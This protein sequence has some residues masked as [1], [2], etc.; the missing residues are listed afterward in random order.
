MAKNILAVIGF[1]G[2]LILGVGVYLGYNTVGK[3]ESSHSKV[4]TEKD[5]T[6]KELRNQLAN[7]DQ[8]LNQLKQSKSPV[9]NPVA[10]SSSSE[11]D[12]MVEQLLAESQKN[13]LLETEVKALSGKMTELV[14]KCSIK[15]QVVKA[16]SKPAPKKAWKSVYH[17]EK[18]QIKPVEKKPEP[19]TVIINK[20]YVTDKGGNQKLIKSEKK[21]VPREYYP[22]DLLK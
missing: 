7:K 17:V 13:L 15:P 16:A 1:F 2:L 12:K 5:N 11:K 3:L 4:I 19:M 10:E 9:V 8:E 14:E 20:V 21:V 6:I 22:N 18:S